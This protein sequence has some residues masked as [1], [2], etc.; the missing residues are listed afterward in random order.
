MTAKKAVCGLPAF[1]V[2]GAISAYDGFGGGFNSG[3][4]FDPKT[5]LLGVSIGVDV[6]VG[7]GVAAR[8]RLTTGKQVTSQ[9]KASGGVSGGVGVSG[10]FQ[11]GQV[12]GGFYH[13]VVGTSMRSPFWERT[14]G[15]VAIGGAGR[16]GNLNLAAQVGV[17]GKVVDLGC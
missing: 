1:G 12:G 4:A 7:A 10:N 2:G 11:A 3:L 9:L 15:A 6:G 8:G 17:A 13:E 16:T 14:Q 5:G